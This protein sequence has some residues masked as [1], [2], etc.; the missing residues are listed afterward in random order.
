MQPSP[1]THPADASPWL[2]RP[3]Q[4]AAQQ[5]H[6]LALELADRLRQALAA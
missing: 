4:D 3:C 6:D 5:A 2:L 1:A